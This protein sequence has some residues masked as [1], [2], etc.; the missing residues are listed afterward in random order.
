MWYGQTVF[1]LNLT[2]FKL[3]QASARAG[4]PVNVQTLVEMAGAARRYA[5]RSVQYL[6]SEGLLA[7]TAGKYE[8]TDAG[9]TVAAGRSSADAPAAKRPYRPRS[10]RRDEVPA[11]ARRDRVRALAR[12]LRVSGWRASDLDAVAKRMTELDV[13][14]LMNAQPDAG[15]T[16]AE[17]AE[18][19]AAKLAALD[20]E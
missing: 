17:L 8:I 2:D 12:F 14:A 20:D 9:R 15:T 5:S 13:A 3:L 4:Q 6:Y 10:A 16:S 19:V 11:N 1:R 7:R 18:V